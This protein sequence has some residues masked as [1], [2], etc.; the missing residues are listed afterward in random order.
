MV[1]FEGVVE[2]QRSQVFL[3]E[4]TAVTEIERVAKKPF[5]RE[6]AVTEIERVMKKQFLRETATVK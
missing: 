2:K 4:V 3:Q 5:L 1:D 6:T